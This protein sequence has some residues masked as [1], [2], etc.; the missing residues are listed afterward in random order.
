MDYEL[1]FYKFDTHRRLFE[2]EHWVFHVS[3]EL[4]VLRIDFYDEIQKQMRHSKDL[5]GKQQDK[6]VKTI[7]DW[8]FRR[9][10]NP[11]DS[12]GNNATLW[13]MSP[14]DF[15]DTDKDAI[16]MHWFREEL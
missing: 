11:F 16:R 6:F 13:N 14:S 7:K 12:G 9:E 1:I 4:K 15:T 2:S 3:P 10:A 8:L 5:K